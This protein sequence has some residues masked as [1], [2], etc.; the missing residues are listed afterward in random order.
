MGFSKSMSR[1]ELKYAAET[2]L[3]MT[4]Q[5]DDSTKTKEQLIAELEQLRAELDD[6]KRM[7]EALRRSNALL[8]AQ[9]G[10]SVAGI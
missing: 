10:A 1:I 6:R 9:C 8:Q 4:D 5:F 3:T 7:E 2:S